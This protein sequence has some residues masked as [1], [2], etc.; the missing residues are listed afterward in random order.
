VLTI[1]TIST[2]GGAGKTTL[3][4]H[5]AVA[6]MRA[7]EKVAVLDT[8]PQ[9]SAS[10]WGEARQAEQPRVLAVDPGE[11]AAAVGA[12]KQDG[13]T[14]V[15]I[16]SAPRA[17]ASAALTCRAADFVLVPCRPSAFDLATVKQ[18][19]AIVAAADR[20]ASSALVLNGCRARS[21]EVEQARSFLERFEAHLSP[22]ELGVRTAY[23]RA[24]QTGRSVQEIEPHG[25]AA[26]EIVAL[27]TYVCER[28]KRRT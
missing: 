14:L 2:K 9:G 28:M 5:L 26:E 15:V 3:T 19:I 6:A 10:A 27:W 11:V 23:A 17:E 7:G 22:V 16:D 4:A 13:Y 1:A 25:A 24:V 12:A 20:V 21:P 8:D 18:T